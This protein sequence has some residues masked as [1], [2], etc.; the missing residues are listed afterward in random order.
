MAGNEAQ[1]QLGMVKVGVEADLA[2]YNKSMKQAHQ[3]AEKFDKAANKNVGAAKKT[4]RAAKDA[5]KEVNTLAKSFR[6]AAD[7]AAFVTGPLGGVASRITLLGSAIQKGYTGVLAFS[8][9]FTGMT[10]ALIRSINE[11]EKAETSFLRT[12]AVIKATGSASGF[13]AGQIKDMGQKIKDTTLAQGEAID[14]AA[15]KLLTFRAVQDEVFREALTLS[16]DLAA[17]GFGSID[18]AAVQL[19][20]ALQDPIVGLES[21]REVGVTFTAM[22]RE[23]IRVMYKAGEVAEA[24]KII[25]KAVRDQVGGAGAGEAGGLTGAYDQLNKQIDLFFK[26]IGNSGPLLQW[27]E[28]VEAATQALRNW[29]KELFPSNEVQI[30]E[31]LAEKIKLEEGLAE[32]E[33]SAASR[34]AF[35]ESRIKMDRDRIEVIRGLIA[36][37]QDKR[38]AELKDQTLAQQAAEESRKKE[39]Q[40]RKDAEALEKK[41]AAAEDAARAAEHLARRRSETIVDL[42]NELAVLRQIESAYTQEAGTLSELESKKRALTVINDLKFA[43]DSAEARKILE[44]VDGHRKLQE[45][46]EAETDARKQAEQAQKAFETSVQNVKEQTSAMKAE[47]ETVGMAEAAAQAYRME[48][49]LLNKTLADFGSISGAQSQEIKEVAKAYGAAAEQLKKV[50]EEQKA[51]EKQAELMAEAQQRFS[52]SLAEG[53]TDAIWN[54]ETAGDAFRNMAIELSKAATQAQILALIQRATGQA[55]GNN[56]QNMFVLFGKALAGAAGS[57][58][59]GG[60]NSGFISS[61]MASQ[62]HSGGV[63]GQDG[64]RR[65]VSSSTFIGA[66]RFHDG[67]KPNE[68]PAILERGEGVI[69]KDE[70]KGGFGSRSIVVNQYIETRDADSFRLSR[71]QVARQTEQALKK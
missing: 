12:Q 63:G 17:V 47:A 33:K 54:A 61:V 71:R 27:T 26:N 43:Q 55:G 65:N 48:Q 70:M 25:L 23:Q 68:F 30:N 20:K 11:A 8:I 21:L 39:E 1:G 38:I 58:G 66:P 69:P 60:G 53:L 52:E 45:S 18:A 56:E 51:A 7:S 50:E 42:E 44:L 19:G 13:T 31:M 46:I 49:E 32:F 28:L 4:E 64:L 3:E 57:S 24:H 29:N 67:L 22:Q 59:G 62:M 40:D 36:A 2:A 41:K 15:Q 6:S 16:Q 9:A 34:T 5:A 37:I 10:Y 35:G 14:R